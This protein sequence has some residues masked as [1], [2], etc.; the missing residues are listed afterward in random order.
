MP[1]TEPNNPATEEGGLVR[2]VRDIRA[3][4]SRADVP[5]DNTGGRSD[6]NDT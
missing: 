2:A 1:I 4:R 5:S 3:A 6:Q